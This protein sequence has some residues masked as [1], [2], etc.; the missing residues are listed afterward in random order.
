MAQYY[1]FAGQRI[2]L[3]GGYS[4]RN[5]PVNQG[6]GAAGGKVL[7]LGEATGGGISYNATFDG[8]SGGSVENIINRIDGQPTALNV[9]GGGALY[10]GAE[11]FLT[12]TM[13]SRFSSPAEADCIIVNQMTQAT[14][15]I[16]ASAAPTI[17]VAFNTWGLNGN[18]AAVL[19]QAGSVS[20]KAL[21]LLYRGEKV[22]DQDNVQMPLMSI[23]YIGAGSAATMTIT[24][25]KLTTT[26]TGGPGSENLD[27]TLANYSSLGALVTYIDGLDAYTCTLLGQS[28]EL[29]SVFDAVTGQDIKSATYDCQG[30]VEALIRTISSSDGFTATLHASAPRIAPDNMTSYLYLTGGTVTAAQTSDWTAVLT[31]LEDYDVDNLVIMSSSTTVQ[32]LVNTH[33]EK[34]NGIQY[35]KYRQW[36]AGAGG[37]LSTTNTKAKKIA[38]MKAL[39]SAYAEYCVSQFQRF[40]CVNNVV[41]NFDPMYLYPMI[42][43]LRYANK[44]GMDVCFKYVNVLS[45]PDITKADREDYAAAGGT[46]IQK[47][48]SVLNGAT[49]FEI[50]VNN[51][52]YQGSQVTRTNPGVVYTINILTKDLEEQVIEKIRALDGAADIMIMSGIENWILTS[53]LPKYRDN[54][55]YITDYVNPVTGVTQKAFDKVVFVQEGELLKM[56]AVL[57]MSVSPRFVFNYLTFITPGQLL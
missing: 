42:A 40:D 44:V 31:M 53:L 41:A 46:L 23:Q 33:C 5:F 17:D 10:Y 48:T 27:I 20:G 22:L 13:D 2:I 16:K 52:C 56:S 29:T 21:T 25:T 15:E 39:G 55:K 45:T 49:N 18:Q 36:G 6:G 7:I 19:V 47:S 57:T 11:F 1:D 38:Q 14:C 43:G 26:I 8:A 37:S 35:K 12:P 34:M 28:D 32:A 30:I 4:K 3:P 50:K 9:F 24:G 54:D 51:T